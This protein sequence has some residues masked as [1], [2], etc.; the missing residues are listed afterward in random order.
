MNSFV[1]FKFPAKLLSLLFLTTL[2]LT[3]NSAAEGS[4]RCEKEAISSSSFIAA[5]K[6][7]AKLLEELNS[8]NANVVIVS[9]VGSDLSKRGLKYTH[10]GIIWRPSAADQWK[11]THLLNNCGNSTSA[12][13]AQGLL[14]FFLDDPFNYDSL[15]TIP[16]KELRGHL[17]DILSEKSYSKIFSNEYSMIAYPFSTE[18]MNSNQFVLETIALAQSR[19][20][21]V[22]L[23]G[24]PQAQA[25]LHEN[26]FEGSIIQLRFFE[27]LF[28]GLFKENVSFRDHTDKENE[29]GRFEFVSVKSIAR[30][31]Q[32]MRLLEKN[33]ELLAGVG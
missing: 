19:M 15:I 26:G 21:G 4:A 27:M 24:R 22:V 10:A 20:E 2:L 11:V 33:Y 13:Y 1:C 28:G 23:Q 5:S 32:K 6:Q 31:L 17:L 25:L 14:D 3:N 18:F 29:T 16:T 8:S 7:S 9:R 12:I 30:Y